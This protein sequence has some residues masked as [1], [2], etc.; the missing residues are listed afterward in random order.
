MNLVHL[1][2]Q[3]RRLPKA[4]IHRS[5]WVALLGL[6]VL[7][8]IAATACV[9]KTGAD[10]IDIFSEQHYAQFYR[11]QEPPRLE[12]VASAQVFVSTST[13]QTLNVPATV[14]GTYNVQVAK[15]L[16]RVN[17]SVCHG[18]NGKGDGP[19]VPFLTAKNS[20]YATE[21]NGTPYNAPPSLIA[22]R[23][24]LSQDAMFGIITNGITVMPKFGLLLTQQQR[25]DII[26]YVYDKQHG[27]GS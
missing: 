24:K 1:R 25:W 9:P 16:F 6:A 4:R 11:S 5:S 22:A 7:A 10:P 12:G 3:P 17:C 18:L 21:N 15:N 14:K 23:D 8:L 26:R 19:I 13:D 20:Y 2:A 27:L